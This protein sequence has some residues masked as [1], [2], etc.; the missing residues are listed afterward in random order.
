[1]GGAYLGSCTAD[2]CKANSERVNELCVCNP[3]YVDM[4]AHC[5]RCGRG[6][7][8]KNEKC[9]AV[10]CPLHSSGSP[11]CRCDVGFA[12]WLEWDTVNDLY[13]G[14]CIPC[15]RGSWAPEGSVMCVKL[16]CP[17]NSENF[18]FCQCRAGFLGT[19][20]WMGANYAGS[21]EPCP[22]GSWKE[23][24]NSNQ[25]VPAPCP[26]GSAGHPDCVC[27]A[28]FAG[29]I[30]WSKEIGQ[31][32]GSCNECPMGYW[33]SAGSP[34]CNLWSCPA[35]S[36][37]H[38]LCRCDSGFFGS[39][40]WDPLK[41][42]QGECHACPAGEYQDEWGKRS[43]KKCG[44]G[45]SS[46]IASTKCF[47]EDC[48]SN[49]EDWANCSC[50]GARFGEITWNNVTQMYEGKCLQCARG[51]VPNE[52]GQCEMVSCP[53]NSEGY[54]FCS[55]VR[56][57]AGE[58]SWDHLNTKY[59]GTCEL[60]SCPPSS[61]GWPFCVCD[62]GT[63]GVLTWSPDEQTFLG[64]CQS[65]SR[66][67]YQD[68]VGQPFCKECREMGYAANAIIGSTSC[69]KMHCPK[70]AFGFPE[71]VCRAGTWT[72][73]LEWDPVIEDYH[74]D[75]FPCEKGFWSPPNSTQCLRVKCPQNSE[76]HPDCYCTDGFHGLLVWNG[77]GS[78]IGTCSQDTCTK[79]HVSGPSC[80][81][82]DGYV[83]NI[84]GECTRCPRYTT[85][86]STS[87]TCQPV[88][89]PQNASNYPHCTCDANHFG[90]LLWLTYNGEGYY[91][92]ECFP[93]P[94]GFVSRPN[95]T[96][97]TK[98]RCPVEFSATTL[99]GE[100]VC[101]DNFEGSIE[102]AMDKRSGQVKFTDHCH[103][104]DKGYFSHKGSDCELVECPENAVHHP[105]C[106]CDAGYMGTI[107]WDEMLNFYTGSCVS[108]GVG[109]S[110]VD[111]S[112]PVFVPCPE[113]SVVS[114]FL[115]FSLLF[116]FLICFSV[117]VVNVEGAQQIPFFT[118]FRGILIVVVRRCLKEL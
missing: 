108:T 45:L 48:P 55:C 22:K 9:V 16:D 43:C 8:V 114:S 39:I 82:N 71:C 14:S 50:S 66:H 7:T 20:T 73:A 86:N 38:P 68:L 115:F 95:S 75:C 13:R 103:K 67:H 110:S 61:F 37:G 87:W 31:F 6:E 44:T 49:S 3:G 40:S 60:L 70:N 77:R 65:C 46:E 80:A 79:E 27:M 54:P 52:G 98:V 90:E 36:V 12:G 112:A 84:D 74:S 34:K 17:A 51:T 57:Y 62:A 96:E 35:N 94:P 83:R 18:P 33:S 11:N 56:G 41:G 2:N 102:V 99:E 64:E 19:I 107:I 118:H 85:W 106:E 15:P 92:G 53:E 78:Y 42:Y 30:T 111:G 91:L 29:T 10:S 69:D 32:L 1:M 59:V 89:C 21:C 23:S 24:G 104:C 105:D 5:Q 47:R 76:G 81:C 109:F 72:H 4:G 26:S 63:S 117:V 97:C 116:V 93:C 28:G 88:P 100:C 113:H 101:P 58:I 25:C